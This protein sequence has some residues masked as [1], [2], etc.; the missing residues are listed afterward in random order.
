[1]SFCAGVKKELLESANNARHCD[2]AELSAI[3]NIRGASD[4]KEL[5][6]YA[7]NIL[8]TDR[9]LKLLEAAFNTERL[10]MDAV[11]NKSGGRQYMLT[12]AGDGLKKVLSATG[13]ADENSNALVVS[14]A[15]CKRAYIKGAFLASARISDPEKA[16]HAEFLLQSRELALKL[17]EM[18]NFFGLHSKLLRRKEHFA[19][20]LKDSEDISDLLKII[21]ANDRV[22]ELE[23]IRAHKNMNNAINRKANVDTANYDKTANASAKQVLDIRFIEKA[24]GFDYLSEPLRQMAELRLSRPEASFKELGEMLKPV[25]SKSGVN[26]RLRKIGEIAEELRG[27]GK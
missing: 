13:A 27:G 14:S 21:E 26:H 22:M 18:I 8:I 19:V 9:V 4:D 20:Y 23:N 2:I 6:I 15:C 5:R 16:Y 12:L 1:M 7:P 3:I 11:I 17:M 10:R 24:G 25:V